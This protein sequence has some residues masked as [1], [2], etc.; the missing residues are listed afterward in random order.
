V[1]LSSSEAQHVTISKTVREFILVYQV[2]ET[3]MIKAELPIQENMDN[4][5]ANV[6]VNNTNARK[7]TK[8]R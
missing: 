4:V 6:L 8:T 2:V 5:E 7:K 1:T 3:L